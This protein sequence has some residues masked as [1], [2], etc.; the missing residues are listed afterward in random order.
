MSDPIK[1]QTGDVVALVSGGPAMTVVKSD[2]EEYG[3]GLVKVLWFDANG[4]MQDEFLA[5]EILVLLC[6]HCLKDS[7]ED[8]PE[9]DDSPKP[10]KE[11]AS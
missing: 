11:R 8:F 7:C 10:E 4:H 2:F 3:A 5:P 9:D 6:P 1:F